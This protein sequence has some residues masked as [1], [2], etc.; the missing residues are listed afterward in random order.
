MIGRGENG[1][2]NFNKVFSVPTHPGMKTE[3]LTGGAVIHANGDDS[4]PWN[5]NGT[6]IGANH[7]CS[8]SRVITS[9]AHGLIQGLRELA[10]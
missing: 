7:G 3:D 5:I 1:Q 9:P 6:Y 10:G 8:D 4:T 2:V